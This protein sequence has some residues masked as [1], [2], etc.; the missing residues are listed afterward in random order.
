MGECV[1]NSIKVAVVGVMLMGVNFQYLVILDT[2][3]YTFLSETLYDHQILHSAKI[4][5]CTVSVFPQNIKIVKISNTHSKGAQ[6]SL[7]L[8]Q[9]ERT[10]TNGG[11]K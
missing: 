4:F 7:N 8:T 1:I 2:L 6:I 11:C 5:I 3:L 9:T 10:S